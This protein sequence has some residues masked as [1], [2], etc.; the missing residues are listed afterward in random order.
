M[1][2]RI[3]LGCSFRG[4][5]V[6][7]FWQVIHQAVAVWMGDTRPDSVLKKIADE[8]YKKKLGRKHSV[9]I[10]EFFVVF[11]LQAFLAYMVP[12]YA[13][14]NMLSYVLFKIFSLL[15]P[16]PVLSR[17]ACWIIRIRFAAGVLF[18]LSTGT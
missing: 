3:H 18:N 8:E 12:V 5:T 6:I 15:V 2:I 9:Q 11:F 16:V 10:A 1:P 7:Y 17:L 13:L 14:L 4:L